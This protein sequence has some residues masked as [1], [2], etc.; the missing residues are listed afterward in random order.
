[1]SIEN[2]PYYDNG[3]QMP[4]YSVPNRNLPMP[5]LANPYSNPSA[6]KNM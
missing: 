5:A 3:K 6:A 1:M 2:N 4:G